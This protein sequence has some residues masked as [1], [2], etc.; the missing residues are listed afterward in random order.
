M[1]QNFLIRRYVLDGSRRFSNY[2]WAAAILLGGMGFFLTGLSSYWNN[3]SGGE[4][5]LA[6]FNSNEISFF[7]QGL[8]MCFYGVLGILLSSYLW[9]TIIWNVGGGF[10]EFNKKEGWIRIFR[11]GF[12]GKSRFIDVYFPIQEIEAIRVELKNSNINPQRTLYLKLKAK[13]E[14][15]L[16]PIGQVFNIEEIEKQAAELA[17]FLKISVY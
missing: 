8:V 10:T 2:V 7:P 13:R 17:K 9:C 5:V 11:W 1:S 4:S 16:N 12:P 15:P 3:N 6:F 14:I